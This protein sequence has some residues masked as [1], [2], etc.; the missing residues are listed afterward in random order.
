L[1]YGQTE[2]LGHHSTVDEDTSINSPKG[3]ISYLTSN[4]AQYRY[5]FR[6]CGL[7]EKIWERKSK[8]ELGRKFR[9]HANKIK[10]DQLVLPFL[11][12][13]KLNNR[14]SILWSSVC[15]AKIVRYKS[16]R[17]SDPVYSQSENTI[18]MLTDL[19]L[20]GTSSG[21]AEDDIVDDINKE[22]PWM[23]PV[24]S[25][26]RL[27][28]LVSNLDAISTAIV[29]IMEN[30]LSTSD[31]HSSTPGRDWVMGDGL[32]AYLR[33]GK[34]YCKYNDMDEVRVRDAHEETERKYRDITR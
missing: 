25:K 18:Q 28:G 4:I 3:I 10:D 11:E 9:E 31:L 22:F 8:D 29:D 15:N 33:S 27:T 13:T 32:A 20:G 19:G 6:K 1:V 26:L 12:M 23:V 17:A 21:A 14:V 7:P 34:V 2:D 16:M 30:R 24:L 5:A